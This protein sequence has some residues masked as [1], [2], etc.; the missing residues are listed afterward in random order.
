MVLE[1]GF[2]LDTANKLAGILGAIVAVG[3]L[4]LPLYRK[5]IQRYLWNFRKK[6]LRQ[7]MP[8]KCPNCSANLLKI[9]IIVADANGEKDKFQKNTQKNSCMN[10]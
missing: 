6:Y 10:S 7:T 2:D 3:A 1:N 8:N 5:P 4:L 9:L